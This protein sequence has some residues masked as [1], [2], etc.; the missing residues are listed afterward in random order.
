M[1][2]QRGLYLHFTASA[3]M[4]ILRIDMSTQNGIDQ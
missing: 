1:L 4:N 2:D 3:V